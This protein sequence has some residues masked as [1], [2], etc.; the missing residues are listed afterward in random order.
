MLER[1]DERDA[2]VLPP[3]R[4]GGAEQPPEKDGNASVETG[5]AHRERPRHFG[6]VCEGTGFR[7]PR[8]RNSSS[9]PEAGG[10]ANSETDVRRTR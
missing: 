3:Y 9:Q 6:P 2:P 10:C 7:L 4:A 1:P 5:L 8:V